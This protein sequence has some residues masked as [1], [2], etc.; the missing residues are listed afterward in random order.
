VDRPRGRW[1]TVYIMRMYK[2]KELQFPGAPFA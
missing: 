2:A 1:V